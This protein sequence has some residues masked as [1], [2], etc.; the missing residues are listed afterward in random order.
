MTIEYFEKYNI[1]TMYDAH[2]PTKYNIV[3]FM[4]TTCNNNT[5]C[6]INPA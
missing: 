4:Y 6:I 3:L 1:Y 5:K 2:V